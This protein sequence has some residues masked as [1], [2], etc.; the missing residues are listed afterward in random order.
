[1]ARPSGLSSRPSHNCELNKLGISSPLWTESLNALILAVAIMP[2]LGGIH[3]KE[4]KEEIR[5]EENKESKAFEGKDENTR[6]EEVESDGT[7]KIGVFDPFVVN[8]G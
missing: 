7:C 8:G 1:M 5:C 2:R 6:Q 3:G 4:S